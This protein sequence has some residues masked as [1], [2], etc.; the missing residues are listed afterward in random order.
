MG[1]GGT[2]YD[3]DR[4]NSWEQIDETENSNETLRFLQSEMCKRRLFISDKIELS[5]Q[6]DV[7]RLHR[8]DKIQCADTF[9]SFIVFG[10]GMACVGLAAINWDEKCDQPLQLFLAVL[11][12]MSPFVAC[13][14]MLLRHWFYLQLRASCLMVFLIVVAFMY[15]GWFM[16]GQVWAFSVVYET[17]PHKGLIVGTNVVAFLVHLAVL[18]YVSKV[19]YYVAFQLRY[20][21]RDMCWACIEDPYPFV[22][23]MDD[24]EFL[25]IEAQFHREFAVRQQQLQGQGRQDSGHRIKHKTR[26]GKYA[27]Q[28]V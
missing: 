14:P 2:D 18:V 7:Q 20:P 13:F 24:E 25:V 9:F 6:L 12:C 4:E 21:C 28:S 10:T 22:E 17:C 5:R 26:G 1:A 19:A 3:D 16:I 8:G 11:G 23:D 27:V 15:C